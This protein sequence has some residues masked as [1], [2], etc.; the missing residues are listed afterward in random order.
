MRSFSSHYSSFVPLYPDLRHGLLLHVCNAQANARTKGLIYF[1]HQVII[2]V[3]CFLSKPSLIDGSH[4]LKQ[5]H[6]VSAES[7]DFAPEW[8]V[9]WKSCLVQL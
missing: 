4:L 5:D 3:S 7:I 2:Q 8:D 6:R 1:F 9:G